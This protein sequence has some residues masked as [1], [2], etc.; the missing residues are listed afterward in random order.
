VLRRPT[1]HPASFDASATKVP[2][3]RSIGHGSS[4]IDD[5]DDGPQSRRLLADLVDV[6][7]LP[8]AAVASR[9]PTRRLPRWRP[10][11]DD[12]VAVTQDT[13]TSWRQ[14][15]RRNTIVDAPSSSSSSFDVVRGAARGGA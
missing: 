8:N 9:V 14:V 4:T 15:P 12:D 3:H 10:D 11:D 1:A 5:D 6:L 2:P 13:Q 7:V